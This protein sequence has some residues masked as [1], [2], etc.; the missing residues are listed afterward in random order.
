MLEFVKDCMDYLKSS[1]DPGHAETNDYCTLYDEL[2]PRALSEKSLT[3]N[4]GTSLI[5]QI[6]SMLTHSE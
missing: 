2:N 5:I 3:R 1:C 4:N 6:T